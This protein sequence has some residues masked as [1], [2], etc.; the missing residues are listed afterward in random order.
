VQFDD[1][2]TIFPPGSLIYGKPFQNEDQL[3]VVNDNLKTWPQNDDRTWKLDAWTF[4]WTGEKFER[5]CLTLPFERYEGQK[6]ITALPFYPL[7]L[8]PKHQDILEELLNRGKKFRS[9]CEAEDGARL[10][11]YKGDSIFG[12]KGLN[13][14]QNNDVMHQVPQSSRVD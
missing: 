3:F 12:Q 14:L 11:E 2:W 7:E 5:T 9:L 6:A 8:H 4:D 1:L 13:G 10:F